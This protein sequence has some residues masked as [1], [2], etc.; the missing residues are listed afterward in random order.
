MAVL[1]TDSI[2]ICN[3][4]STMLQIEMYTTMFQI[5]M[6]D[7][8]YRLD[9]PKYELSALQIAFGATDKK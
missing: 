5:E 2:F 1:L 4:Y 8:N 7:N 3:V 9:H 6:S